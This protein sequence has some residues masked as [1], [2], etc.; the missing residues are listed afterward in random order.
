MA[1]M[2]DVIDAGR[3]ISYWALDEPSN[4]SGAVLRRDAF[5][6]NDATD[7]T[8]VPSVAGKITPLA[9]NFDDAVPDR[10]VVP[11]NTSLD[12]PASGQLTIG[13]WIQ[14]HDLTVAMNYFSKWAATTGIIYALQYA[15]IGG[16][17]HRF[18]AL[19][20]NSS[21]DNTGFTVTWGTAVLA[22]TWYF[23][24]VEID[25]ANEFASI[26]VNRTG[27]VEATGS[28]SYS[29]VDD[30]NDLWIGS[31]EATGNDMDGY[32]NGWA[33]IEGILST[34]EKDDWYLSGAGRDLNELL[35]G[36][37][38]GRLFFW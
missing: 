3:V 15:D 11:Y 31:D 25:E 24:L 33:L 8:T 16:S 19:I 12:I 10:L 2:Q 18:R 28:L 36:S 17:T 35:L 9:A 21:G 20:G 37:G 4:G 22:N 13:G 32:L 29:L 1:T 14:V 23:V 34:D 26:E 30:T 6:G 38:K 7:P 5:G 27:R